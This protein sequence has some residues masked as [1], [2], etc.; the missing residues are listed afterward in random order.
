MSRLLAIGDIH[1]CARALDALLAEVEPTLEDTIVT[2]GDYVDRGPDS[3][4]VIERLLKLASATRLI[5]LRGNHEW[6]MLQA[7]QGPAEEQEWFRYAGEETLASYTAALGIDKLSDVPASHWNFMEK[8]CVPWHETDTH[9]FVHANAA[10][11]LSLAEQPEDTLYWQKLLAGSGP[12]VSGKIMVCGHTAQPSG[13]P[14]NLG[15]AICL[16]TMAYNRGWLTCLD[17]DN[18]LYWQA[19][20]RGELRLANLDRFGRR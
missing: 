15:H 5:A 20:Q 17:V 16:D 9:F 18:R 3:Y 10:P 8:T 7:R 11:D 4:G 6:M 14:L 19:N 13:K 2:L 1:G 12:H